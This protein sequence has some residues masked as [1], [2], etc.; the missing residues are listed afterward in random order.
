MYQER[1]DKDYDE[2]KYVMSTME[3]SKYTQECITDIDLEIKKYHGYRL[4]VYPIPMSTIVEWHPLTDW[5]REFPKE[6][7]KMDNIIKT[8]NQAKFILDFL[9]QEILKTEGNK[10]YNEALRTV[11]AEFV[12]RY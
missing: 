10:R 7:N 5:S 9:N 2:W 11:R 6:V 12:G 8:K 4:F 3:I 1:Y